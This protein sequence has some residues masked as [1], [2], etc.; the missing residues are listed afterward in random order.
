MIRRISS[1]FSRFSKTVS[2]HRRMEI[3]LRAF[4]ITLL[5][6]V[7]SLL[8]AS[9]LSFSVMSIFSSPDKEDSQ[10]SDFYAQVADR[11]PVRHLDSEI[12]L[13]DIENAGRAEITEMLEVV[14]L[15]DPKAVGLD[16]MFEDP[17]EGD[18]RLIAAV[19]SV[20]NIVLPV[21]VDINGKGEAIP[22][23][24]SYFHKDIV[25]NQGVVNLAAKSMNGT[26]R[27]FATSFDGENGKTI[28][29]FP[30][31]I[32]RVAHP[33]KVRTLLE[34]GNRHEFIDY[35]SRE[36]DVIP[37]GEVRDRAEELL[38][39]IIIIGSLSD[40]SDIHV[41]P[42]DS[43][44]AGVL[45]HAYSA[46]TILSGNYYTRPTRFGDWL[47]AYILSL[48]TIWISIRI[49]A[50]VKG[51]VVRLLQLIIVYL[52]VQ[53]GYYLFVDHR[54]VFNFTY[55]LVMIAFGMF[56][57]DLW[58]GTSG[59]ARIISEKRARRRRADLS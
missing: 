55:T 25:R 39:K 37:I 19:T 29:S 13:I 48:F 57:S 17:R 1:A 23:D 5:A 2:T 24:V 41:T 33:E 6:F 7:L 28:P 22:K 52:A 27:E 18:E 38:G 44:L 40:T 21:G 49:D 54:I 9:P 53:I 30:V 43:R 45:I 31:E 8:L 14:A 16:V 47:I 26:I 35:P 20:P 59:L 11:R 32:V 34:R 46:G 15:C 10:V 42:L 56:A 3:C 12:V 58:H 51:L 50:R 36:F 4:G